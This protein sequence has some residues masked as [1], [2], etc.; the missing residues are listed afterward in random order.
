[1]YLFC[2]RDILKRRNSGQSLQLYA[3]LALITTTFNRIGVPP[4][5]I[6]LDH[7]FVFLSGSR[8]LTFSFHYPAIRPNISRAAV[9]FFLVTCQTQHIP[10]QGVLYVVEQ[11]LY[12]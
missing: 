8:R 2:K 12:Q 11:Y 1:M 3:F 10:L 7:G 9:V 5:E 6:D 4:N